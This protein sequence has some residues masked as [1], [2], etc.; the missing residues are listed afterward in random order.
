MF[1]KKPATAVIGE[2]VKGA[3]T[4]TSAGMMR[5]RVTTLDTTKIVP[6]VSEFSTEEYSAYLLQQRY[7]APK[8]GLKDGAMKASYAAYKDSHKKHRK[9]PKSSKKPNPMCNEHHSNYALTIHINMLL[10]SEGQPTLFKVGPSKGRRVGNLLWLLRTAKSAD[11]NNHT[12]SFWTGVTPSTDTTKYSHILAQIKLAAEKKLKD[13]YKFDVKQ[14]D[15]YNKALRLFVLER[16]RLQPLYDFENEDTDAGTLLAS[17]ATRNAAFH[18]QLD[19]VVVEHYASYTILMNLESK[20]VTGFSEFSKKLRILLW[21]GCCLVPTDFFFMSHELDVLNV[22]AAAL[23]V[24]EGVTAMWA[25]CVAK[26]VHWQVLHKEVALCSVADS[27][28][29][30]HLAAAISEISR[31][32][33]YVDQR[34]ETSF[35]AKQN[36]MFAERAKKAF[37][38]EGLGTVNI[39][40]RKPVTQAPETLIEED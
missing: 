18:K 35:L 23:G 27:N 8:N 38:A 24:S 40:K 11:P 30:K 15:T 36:A 29:H 37:S 33:D 20:A 22:Q 4:I 39:A 1:S 32:E 34:P 14:P 3:Q 12:G 26:L 13:D 25:T 5:E 10:A 16:I 31:Q 21:L 7:L 17:V 9:N 28:Y 6:G 2:R 19:T